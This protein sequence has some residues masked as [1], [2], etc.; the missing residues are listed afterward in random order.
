MCFQENSHL[1]LL[2]QNVMCN[3]LFFLNVIVLI[4]RWELKLARRN[5]EEIWKNS[6]SPLRKANGM[7]LMSKLLVW[8][9]PFS[10]LMISHSCIPVPPQTLHPH[11]CTSPL[12]ALPPSLIKVWVLHKLRYRLILLNPTCFFPV[13]TR[14]LRHELPLSWDCLL[15][16]TVGHCLVLQLLSPGVVGGVG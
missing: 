2:K 6:R 12:P 1:L 9:H 11:H 16:L 4:S 3:R 5:P 10:L 7:R 14:L 15:V 13:E 8:I